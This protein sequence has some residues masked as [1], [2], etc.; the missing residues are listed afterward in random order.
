MKNILIVIFFSICSSSFSQRLIEVGYQVDQAGNYNFYC[1]NN[2]YCNYILEMGFTTLDNLKCDVALPYRGII[3]PGKNK[4]FKLS[5]ENPSAAFQFK[6]SMNYAKGCIN[7]KADTGFTYLLP[8]SPGKET[9]AYV[10]EKSQ[11]TKSTESSAGGNAQQIN[12][13]SKNWYLIRMRMKPGDTIFAAR[14]GMVTEVDDRSES[15]DA[16]ASSI[17]NENYVEIVHADCSF[18]EYGILRKGSA[19]VKPGQFVEA[20]TPVGL[21]GGDKFGRGSEIRFSVH[22]N[23]EPDEA[24]MNN[25]KISWEYVSL[26]FWTKDNGKISLHHG[27]N[28]ISEFPVAILRQELKKP[29]TKKPTAKP[30]PKAKSK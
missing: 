18:G 25:G 16:G 7:P 28:Y 27:G 21:V 15:N 12:P 3:K 20:G 29:E 26:K 6:Y 10:M 19:L 1:N 24:G 9:Q 22:Y 8:L 23:V 14:R 13:G 2:A 11:Q 17:G 30:K 4:L 5:K